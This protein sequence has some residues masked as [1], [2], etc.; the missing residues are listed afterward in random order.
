ML[1]VMLHV[2][3]PCA[4]EPN[5][6]WSASERRWG[7]QTQDCSTGRFRELVSYRMTITLG[8]S[9]VLVH[10]AIKWLLTWIPVFPLQLFFVWLL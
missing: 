10:S 2:S 1:H 8:C 3:T 9:E 5:N 4:S 6:R 7:T